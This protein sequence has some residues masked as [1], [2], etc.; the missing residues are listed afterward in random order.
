MEIS[1]SAWKQRQAT[2]PEAP[3]TMTCTTA[4]NTIIRHYETPYG[5]VNISVFSSYYYLYGLEIH[6]E[7]RGQGHGYHLLL[8]VIQD[9]AAL[10]PLPLQLQVSGENAPAISLYKK[11]GF[12]I[13]ETLFGYLY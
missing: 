3:L 12:Q 1:L 6:Q 9:L 13:T 7:D 8:Q 5:S 2:D 11:T 10:N 4:D